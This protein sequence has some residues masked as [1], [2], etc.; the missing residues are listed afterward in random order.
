M[1]LVKIVMKK[2]TFIKCLWKSINSRMKKKSKEKLRKM[3]Y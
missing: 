1:E 3:N 2:L